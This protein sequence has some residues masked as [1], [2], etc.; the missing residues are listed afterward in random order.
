MTALEVLQNFFGHDQFRPGQEEIISD[1]LEGKDVLGIL[2]TGGGKSMC[3]QVPA[4]MHPGICLVVSPLI[5]LMIDQVQELKQRGINAEVLHSGLAHR[6]VDVLLDNCI[7]GNVH[8]LY[9]S[10]ERI[11]STLFEARV[12]QM[13]V[14]LLAVDE[15]HCI[16]QWGHDFRPA[17]R[18]I[19]TLREWLPDV[20]CLALT[21]SATPPVAKDIVEQLEFGEN[22]QVV[23]QSFARDN[24]S[25][26]VRLEEDKDH[27]LLEMLK[28]VQGSVIIYV[29]SRKATLD[30]A[31]FLYT[32]G[33]SCT[34]YHAGLPSK[35]RTERQMAWQHG[36]IPI[37]VATNA[38]GMGIN[39]T[40]VRMVIHYNLPSDM[41]SY[42]QEAGR[43]GR[44]GLRAYAAVLLNPDD[45]AIQERILSNQFPSRELMQRV[46]QALANYYSLAV[47]SITEQYL[48]FDL[49]EFAK[50][51]HLKPAE[52]YH[53]LV[54]LEETGLIQLSQ[55]IYLP[56]R[57]MFKASK[58]EVYKFEIANE[59]FEPLVK[60]MLRLYG[61]ELYGHFT[62]ISEMQLARTLRKGVSEIYAQ[63]EKLQELDILDY[64]RS[65]EGPQILFTTPRRDAQNLQIDYKALETRQQQTRDKWQI[66]KAYAQHNKMCRM[67]F[68]QRYFG[69]E[70]KSSCG[71]CDICLEW[72]RHVHADEEERFRHHILEILEEGPQDVEYL[73]QM[74][75]PD[76]KEDFI[77]LVRQMVDAQEI[78]YQDN[79]KLVPMNYAG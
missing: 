32:H 29:R 50:R 27:K 36:R 13:N 72:Q 35:E 24:L 4:L 11:Q 26:L 47:G 16:S 30:I 23:Q 54:K 46:Y 62:A 55:G 40:D 41:E 15:A 39:K 10:P 56:S 49:S 6:E 77:E 31:R 9:I 75:D 21:A 8:F 61:G 44:D 52:S 66:M 18:N 5:A 57:V 22:H 74:L 3:F 60:N 37:I 33:H 38:F 45:L 1:I 59:Q 17:Y 76:D 53:A 65:K 68:I 71:K 79:W 69:E 48:P 14:T 67:R 42:Y 51:Y 2:P 7:Y 58:T 70:R 25:F 63:L 12:K 73:I 43:A 28:K 20:P 19:H 64:R 78:R 34:F